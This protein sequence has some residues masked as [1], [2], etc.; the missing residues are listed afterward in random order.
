[1]IE[2]DFPLLSLTIIVPL[3][4]AVLAG[5]IRNVDLSKH[6]AFFIAVL[7]FLL[8]ICVLILFDASKSEFQ[9]VERRQW[10]PILN[11]E[12]LIGVDGISVLFLPLTALLTLITML[13]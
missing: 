10:I 7:S 9:L 11:I 5:S 8:T 3:L 1:M 4:G 12:Y 2:A 6:V 13:A